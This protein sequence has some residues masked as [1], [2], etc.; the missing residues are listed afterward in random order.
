[1][2]LVLEHA[3]EEALLS[4]DYVREKLSLAVDALAVSTDPIQER[5]MQAGFA[6]SSLTANDFSE[7]EERNLWGHIWHS[8]TE[9]EPVGPEG[10]IR[11][12]TSQLDDESALSL[13]RD[14]MRLHGC[15]FPIAP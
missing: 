10:T 13:V 14:I 7:G 15:F 11:T 1:L 4:D 9:R 8:L 2:R 12:T 5:L 3:N 6:M